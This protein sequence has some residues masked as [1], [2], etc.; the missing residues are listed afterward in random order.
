MSSALSISEIRNQIN[1]LDE[2]LIIVLAK[3]MNAVKDVA[4]YKKD[5]NLP[6]IQQDRIADLLSFWHNC[7]EKTNLDK[8][9]I[10]R[11][12]YVVH[13]ESVRKQIEQISQL[14]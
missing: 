9:F 4:T 1:S 10:T 12:F 3:R 2:E 5:N 6:V 13:D 11:L 8:E 7:A 14:N